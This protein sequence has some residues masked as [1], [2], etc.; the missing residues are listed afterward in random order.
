MVSSVSSSSLAS[1]WA[2]QIFSKLDTKNQGYIDKST[3]QDA[4]SSID[5]SSSSSSS[6]NVDQLFSSIDTDSDGKITQSELTT[7][8]QKVADQLNSQFDQS[9]MGMSGAGGPG[10]PGGAGGPPPGPPPSGSGDGDGDSDDSGFTKDQLTQQLQSSDVSSDTKR[11]DLISS[12]VS[13]FDKADTD[14]DG[15]VTRNEAMS[16]AKTL[17]STSSTSST[18]A[19]TS[20]SD[21]SGSSSSSSSTSSNSDATVMM[22]IL[23]LMQAYGSSTTDNSYS[24][25]AN[26]ISVSA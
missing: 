3:L 9:R 21:S 25:L 16:Y 20:T 23:K 2:S 18:S 11:S 19:V 5:S 6:T 13:N 17:D 8:L 1:S 7:T 22:Q 14:G 10:G 15:K 4:F 12:I 24:L 26:S